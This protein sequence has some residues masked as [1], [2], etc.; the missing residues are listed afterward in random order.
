MSDDIEELEP[1]ERLRFFCS[2]KLLPQA[3]LDSEELFEAVVEEIKQLKK[4]NLEVVELNERFYSREKISQEREFVLE[5]ENV[6]LKKENERIS[7]EARRLAVGVRTINRREG[8]QVP[9]SVTGDDEPCYWQ[10]SEWI[11]YI[12]DLC[13]NVESVLTTNRK[14]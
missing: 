1:I 3:W 14:V 2:E 12:F 6:K 8:H 9:E 4:D 13:E 7:E 10:R 11:D 5:E